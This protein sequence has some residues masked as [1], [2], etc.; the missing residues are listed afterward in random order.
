MAYGV[1]FFSRKQLSE[2]IAT[3]NDRVTK[4]L[5]EAVLSTYEV[6]LSLEKM[7]IESLGESR[8]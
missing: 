1:Q 7:L 8:K 2:I 3:T 4:S 5:A 6:H